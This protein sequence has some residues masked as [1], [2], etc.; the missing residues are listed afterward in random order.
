MMIYRYKD[1]SELPLCGHWGLLGTTRCHQ[2][3]IDEQLC[4]KYQGVLQGSI[5]QLLLTELSPLGA[6][7]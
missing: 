2:G 5:M 1:L 4:T 3:V 6:R 7:S